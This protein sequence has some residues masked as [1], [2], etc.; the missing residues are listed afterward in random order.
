MLSYHHPVV[1]VVRFAVD[2]HVG[3]VHGET[4]HGDRHG[5]AI[6]RIDGSLHLNFNEV[7]L[8]CGRNQRWELAESSVSLAN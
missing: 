4:E 6:D 7:D 3:D 5:C 1:L 2:A 8:Q